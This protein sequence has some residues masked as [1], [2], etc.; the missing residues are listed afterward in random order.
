MKRYTVYIIALM[1]ESQPTRCGHT[2]CRRLAGAFR[3]STPE[4]LMHW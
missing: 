2:H 4:K 1:E 3:P